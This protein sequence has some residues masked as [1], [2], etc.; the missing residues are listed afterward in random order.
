M[1]IRKPFAGA[2]VAL[3]FISAAAGFSPSNYSIPSYKQSDKALHFIAFFLLTLAFY[4]I[5]ET[6]RRKVLQYTFI[7]C[8]IGLGVAS[9]VVQGLLPI[10][11]EFDPYDIAANVSGS[12]IALALCNWYHKRMI[13]RKRA[14]RGYNA[15]AGDDEL[16]VE[17]GEGSGGQ[18]A[19]V[20][21][22]TVDD[23]LDRWDENEEDWETTDP[24]PVIGN[25]VNAATVVA[26]PEDLDNSKKRSG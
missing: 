14:A 26:V 5:L 19:G 4:W 1:R 8:T 15:V 24:D 17:L 22:S 11:R 6:S 12:L 18:E 25:G 7:V 9:E 20:V 2:F 16:D 13:E 10:Q 21:R 3:I 23:E